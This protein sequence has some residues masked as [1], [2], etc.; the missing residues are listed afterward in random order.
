M[1]IFNITPSSYGKIDKKS[2]LIAIY[3]GVAATLPTPGLE[4]LVSYTQSLSVNIV[5]YFKTM[6]LKD[7]CFF[8]LA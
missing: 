4:I 2:P 3:G 8:R 7:F 5:R 6:N 1:E